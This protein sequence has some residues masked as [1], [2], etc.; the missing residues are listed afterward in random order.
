[1]K[2]DKFRYLVA[3]KYTGGKVPQELTVYEFPTSEWA[4]FDCVGPNPQTLQ[5]VSSFITYNY[6]VINNV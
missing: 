4:V 5:S 1:M 2:K 3:G 6:T